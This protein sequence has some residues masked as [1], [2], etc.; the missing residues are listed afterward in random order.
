MN[1]DK[2]YVCDIYRLDKIAYNN[3]DFKNADRS[4]GFSLDNFLRIKRKT[5]YVKTALVYYSINRGGFIDMKTK[6]FYSLGYPSVIGELFV[7]VHKS[8]IFGK[9]IMGTNRRYYS[10]KKILK[11][12]NEYKEGENNECE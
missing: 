1:I 12:Y 3:I 6:E 4:K 10:K 11:R 9:D 7:D 5:S 8:K 2:V